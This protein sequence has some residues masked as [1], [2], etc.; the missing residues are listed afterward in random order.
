MHAC[1]RMENKVQVCILCTHAYYLNLVL[2]IQL[3]Y[4]TWLSPHVHGRRDTRQ[5]P[6][7][8]DDWPIRMMYSGSLASPED[9][10]CYEECITDEIYLPSPPSPS[11]PTSSSRDVPRCNTS[12]RVTKK[13]EG[14]SDRICSSMETV[15]YVWYVTACFMVVRSAVCTLL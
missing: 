6:C 8:E 2:V 14:V 4:G 3:F 1:T 7:S 9:V 5:P 12:G 11:S 10:A 13:G 15:Y